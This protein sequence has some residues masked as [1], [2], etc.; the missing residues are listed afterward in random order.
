MQIN[1]ADAFPEYQHNI[2]P[3]NESFM[4]NVGKLD[5]GFRVVIGIA[6][7]SCVFFGPQTHW[8]W[9]GL[10]PLTTGL[11]GKCPIYSVFGIS[12]R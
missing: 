5:R 8:G 9:L 10:I 3:L 1:V 7:I 4:M 6:A 11:F 12:S 2:L